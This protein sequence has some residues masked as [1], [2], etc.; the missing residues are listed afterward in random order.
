MHFFLY[1][2]TVESSNCTSLTFWMFLFHHY[3]SSK[4][5]DEMQTLATSHATDMEGL[6]KENNTEASMLTE[7]CVLDPAKDY[8]KYGVPTEDFY[9]PDQPDE[10][11]KCAKND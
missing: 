11:P 10:D 7:Y 4:A 2:S 5:T 9:Q 8:G 6:T 1:Y 3:S